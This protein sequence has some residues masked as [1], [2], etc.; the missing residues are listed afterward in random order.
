MKC[1]KRSLPGLCRSVCRSSHL[2]FFQSTLPLK[3]ISPSSLFTFSVNKWPNAIEFGTRLLNLVI[4]FPK[5]HL[6]D[7]NCSTTGLFYHI[8]PNES[9]ALINASCFLSENNVILTCMISCCL[10]HWLMSLFD[11]R[12]IL[13]ER[14]C[15]ERSK[16]FPVRVGPD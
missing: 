11:M 10:L 1:T 8:N 6:Q 15:S 16:F 14:I 3:Y 12:S 4:F 2:F 13:K 9:G 5:Y 7:L